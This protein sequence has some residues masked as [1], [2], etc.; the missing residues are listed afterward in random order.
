MEM[1][2]FATGRD[3]GPTYLRLLFLL[4]H[5]SPEDEL[6]IQAYQNIAQDL[7]MMV[8]YAFVESLDKLS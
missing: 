6:S 5:H 4:L 7:A 2:Q 1:S 3:N 8:Q